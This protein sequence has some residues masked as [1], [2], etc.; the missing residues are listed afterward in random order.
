MMFQ[1][2]VG[3]RIMLMPLKAGG[4]IVGASRHLANLKLPSSILPRIRSVTSKTRPLAAHDD[5]HPD[6]LLIVFRIPLSTGFPRQCNVG[7][8]HDRAEVTG[9]LVEASTNLW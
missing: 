2:G 8:N 9:S 6:P 4:T 1:D 3:Y 7:S 5:G